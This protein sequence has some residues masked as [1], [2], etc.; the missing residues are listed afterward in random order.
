VLCVQLDAWSHNGDYSTR[1][2]SGY[3]GWLASQISVV[4]GITNSN[5]KR[6]KAAAL[7]LATWEI[8]YDSTDYAGS[9]ADG[10]DLSDGKFQYKTTGNIL[11][12]ANSFLSAYEADNTR[13]DYRFYHNPIPGSSTDYQD[14]I[15]LTSTEN[16]KPSVPAPA[17]IIPFAVGLVASL[18]RKRK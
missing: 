4:Q 11:S 12:Y 10:L 15:G 14:Y 16:G 2:V 8:N 3:A 5:E 9:G 1:G 13:R 6:D 17:A 7:A 18:K